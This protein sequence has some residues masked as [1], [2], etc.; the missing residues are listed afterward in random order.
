[1]DILDKLVSLAQIRGRVDVQC[2]FQENWYVRQEPVQTQGQ[3]HIVAEGEGYL[4]VDGCDARL[5]KAGDVVL[6][7]RVAGHIISSSV[8]CDNTCD[9][10]EIVQ[11]GVFT[12]KKSGSAGKGMDLF[13]ARF[14]YDAQADLI[15][16]LPETVYLKV[17]HPSLRA[18]IS[19]L[20]YEAQR[21]EEGAET[22]VNAL[23]SVLLVLLMRVYLEQGN[24]EVLAGTL[25]GWQ[26]YRLRGVVQAVLASPEYTWSVGDMAAAANMSRAQ[27]MRLFKQQIGVSPH[28]FVSRIRLQQAALLLKNTADSVLSVGLSVGFRSE[29]HFGKAFKK[30]YG[31]SP[32]QYRKNGKAD[33]ASVPE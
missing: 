9:V 14:D 3:V 6:F 1:M 28:A 10:P 29:T 4:K 19:M 33:L 22:V 7:P 11:N 27:L 26:D 15:K 23:F 12:L 24:R 13:C 21:K 8:A 25:N 32:G 5:L 2:R 17:E 18:L 30:Q 20:E 16:S 31:M